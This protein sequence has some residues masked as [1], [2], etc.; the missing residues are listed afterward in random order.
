MK[1]VLCIMLVTSCT[2]PE[3]IESANPTINPGESEFAALYEGRGLLGGFACDELNLRLEIDGQQWPYQ[4]PEDSF[5][6]IW[7]HAMPS[8]TEGEY[9]CS[10]Y[11]PG[12]I[13]TIDISVYQ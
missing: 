11:M 2:A 4:I 1:S 5:V 7:L 8:V 10:I 9:W 13:D 3:L 6:E 12:R